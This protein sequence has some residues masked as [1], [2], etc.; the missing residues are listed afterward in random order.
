[1][2]NKT[3]LPPIVLPSEKNW[4][5]SISIFSQGISICRTAWT[6]LLY[7]KVW[8][9]KMGKQDSKKIF[10]TMLLPLPALRPIMIKFSVRLFVLSGCNPTI[11][12]RL[13]RLWVIVANLGEED[14]DLLVDVFISFLNLVV[15]QALAHKIFWRP[16]AELFCP[17]IDQTVLEVH[18]VFVAV[19][20]PHKGSIINQV[21]K[22]SGCGLN[23][24]TFLNRES[25][26]LSSTASPTL[27]F[28]LFPSK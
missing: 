3:S 17:E 6:S 12:R 13:A 26:D 5:F 23:E 11:L 19:Q 18:R 20:L 16:G 9:S 15:A 7:L 22:S 24:G 25:Y 8:L 10:A 4:F 1:M 14:Q 28:A 2:P 27:N 21:T